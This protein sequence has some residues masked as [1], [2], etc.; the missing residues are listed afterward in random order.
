MTFM[1]WLLLWMTHFP[2]AYWFMIS[3]CL[4]RILCF[5]LLFCPSLW[6]LLIHLSAASLFEETVICGVWEIPFMCTDVWHMLVCQRVGGEARWGHLKFWPSFCLVP[7]IQC[8]SL[9]TGLADFGYADWAGAASLLSLWPTHPHPSTGVTNVCDH[10]TIFLTFETGSHYVSLAGLELTEMGLLPKIQYSRHT[11]PH[12]LS[13]LLFYMGS[14]G[15]KLRSLSLHS[16][17]SHPP[18]LLPSPNFSE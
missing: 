11:P 7:W 12:G 2:C 14:G 16:E 5:H 3:S 18:D 17:H 13:A 10:T 6:P 15:S 9:S 1:F 8:F 4:H